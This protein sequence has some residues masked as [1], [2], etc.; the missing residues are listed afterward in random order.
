VLLRIRACGIC[1][2]D[3]HGWDGSSGR[4]HPP[5]IMG[6]EAAGE[7]TALGPGV[8]GWT[9]GDR[10]TFD[11]MLY[12]G[13][14]ADCRA[15]HTNLCAHRRVFGVA[16]ADYNQPGAFAEFLNVPARLLYRLPDTLSFEHAALV[17]PTA[18]ALHAIRRAPTKPTDW[19]V[20]IGA[21]LIGLLVIQSLRAADVRNIIAL[22][23][24]DHRLAVA[25]ELGATH[26]INSRSGDPTAEV[27]ALTSGHGA[28]HVFEVVGM[29]PTLNLAINLA[30]RGGYVTLVGN[31]APAT[32]RFPLQAVVTREISLLGSCGATPE[33]YHRALELIASGAIHATAMISATAPL[34]DGPAWF[35]QL[36]AD[37]G[38]HLKVILTP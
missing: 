38:E 1:G 23:L 33:D 31:L 22:D 5:L 3:L 34:A 13:Q 21:G 14:C 6:H 12:C 32:Q 17:E 9:V 4:R 20:V 28:D 10:V 25:R 29:E 19:V 8:D 36:S 24:V 15:D 30:R 18:V 16:P 37:P 27:A 11:S 35:D 7:I 2:S 26:T